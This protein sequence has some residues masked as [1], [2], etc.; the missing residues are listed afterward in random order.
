MHVDWRDDSL[1]SKYLHFSEKNEFYSHQCQCYELLLKGSYLV[2]WISEL[3]TN[4]TIVPHLG[5]II[6]NNLSFQLHS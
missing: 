1:V 5:G 6:K 3:F 4:H 2:L